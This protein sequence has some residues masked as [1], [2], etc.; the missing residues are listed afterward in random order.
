LVRLLVLYQYITGILQ[1]EVER[2]R[3]YAVP[4]ILI[5]WY[6]FLSHH[7]RRTQFSD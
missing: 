4:R 1:P 5:F 2:S 6:L 7:F 3:L